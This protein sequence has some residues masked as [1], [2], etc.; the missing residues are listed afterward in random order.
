M[1]QVPAINND[2]ARVR[3][4]VDARV[5]ALLAGAAQLHPAADD[6]TLVN[7]PQLRGPIL[8]GRSDMWLH[9]HLNDPNPETKFPDPDMVLSGRRYWRLGTV[10]AWISAQAGRA[11][12]R[13]PAATGARAPDAAP[14]SGPADLSRDPGACPERSVASAHAST[15]AFPQR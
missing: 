6:E 14:I 8:G 10:R 11:K 9:R 4:L 5:K 7:A 2:E 3:A 15:P 12:T 1:S 13:G